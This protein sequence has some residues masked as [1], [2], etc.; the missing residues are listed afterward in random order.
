M[1]SICQFS[2]VLEMAN[3]AKAS[4]GGLCEECGGC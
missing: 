1:I 4:K 3:F 2:I